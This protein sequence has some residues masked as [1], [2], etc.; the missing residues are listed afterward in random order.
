M[1]ESRLNGIGIEYL[2]ECT[3]RFLTN[4]C[5]RI[6]GSGI[7]VT[8]TYDVAFY[9]DQMFV[10]LGIDRPPSVSRAGSKRRAEYLAGRTV[11]RIAQSFFNI[12]EQVGIR[13]SGA[14][15]W[16]AGLNGSISHD[17]TRCACIVHAGPKI[18]LG[19]DTETIVN[20]DGQEAILHSVADKSERQLISG[21]RDLDI[22]A[23]LLFSAKETLFKALYPKVGNWFG[24]DCARLKGLPENGFLPLVLNKT[25]HCDH[26][27]GQ[28]LEIN[29]EVGTSSVL[30]WL[31]IG[32]D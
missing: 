6:E 9:D 21:A 28:V 19:I 22:M 13:Q 16:P 32:T 12:E 27:R 3:G 20:G 17:G 4:V 10:V 15:N 1:N 24:F 18:Y 2:L 26:W 25:L 7:I 30:T 11:S 14:P 23:T 5:S 31:T 8:A 29:Y